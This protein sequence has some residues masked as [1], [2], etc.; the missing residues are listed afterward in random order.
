MAEPEFVF[1]LVLDLVAF[2]NQA[3]EWYRRADDDT[4]RL[5]LKTICSHFLLTDKILSFEAPE[6]LRAVR[7]FAACLS[8]RGRRDAL[9]TQAGFG[10]MLQE[11]A[12]SLT[13]DLAWQR[14]MRRWEDAF[15]V[16]EHL[17]LAA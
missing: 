4:K 1:E 5:I 11:V 14:D 6:W 3:L 15:G 8:E 13:A 7:D 16:R 10:A 12:P 9:R 2:S 17:K